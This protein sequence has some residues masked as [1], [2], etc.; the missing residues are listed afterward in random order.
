M[1]RHK[2]DIPFA[3]KVFEG[4]FLKHTVFDG[5]SGKDARK[6]SEKARIDRS[7]EQDTRSGLLNDSSG[8]GAQECM[9]VQV[10]R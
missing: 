8:H 5:G 2:L 9:E 7:K 3:C 6:I 1:R 4:D 10:K